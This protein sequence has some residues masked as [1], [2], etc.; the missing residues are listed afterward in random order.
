MNDVNAGAPSNAVGARTPG[1]PGQVGGLSLNAGNAQIS[2]SW[3]EPPNN[4]E[5]ITSYHLDIDPGGD[6]SSGD[7][8]YVFGG[9]NNGTQYGIRVQACN[10][11]GCGAWS[12]FQYATPRAPVHV[13]WSKGASAQGQPNCGSSYCRW[14]NVSGSGLTPGRTYSVQCYSNDWGAV[15]GAEQRHRQRQR[16]R[17]GRQRLLLRLP[18]RRFL[19]A[20]RAGR[21]RERTPDLRQL[22]INPHCEGHDMQPATDQQAEWFSHWFNA[23]LDNV[24]QVIKGKRDQIALA[25]VCVFSEGHLLVDDVPGTGKTSLAKAIAHSVKGTWSRIQFTPD[26]LPSDVTGGLVYNQSQGTFDFRRGAVF[27]NVVLADEINR[28]SPKTQAALLEVMEERHVTV[29]GTGY[30][31][32]RPFVVLATQN[33]VEQ[34]G[35]YRLPEAQLDRFLMR[36][37]L[38]YPDHDHEVDVLRMLAD[39]LRP[40]GLSPVMSTSDVRNMI[41][42]AEHVHV[43]DSIRS[44]VVRLCAATRTLPELRLGVS[45]RGAIGMIRTSRALAAAQGR[46]FVTADDVRIVA[47]AVMGHRMLLTPEAELGKVDPGELVEQI[48]DRVD[49]PAAMRAS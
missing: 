23:L 16:R 30:D 19:G 14:I 22:T 28:A 9:L 38:G 8:S 11:V 37:T 32:P 44:Y 3:S 1:E 20:A 7:R 33:P 43:E 4:G 25:L 29:D 45:T 17:L 49:L 34:E 48:I 36:T 12:G 46:P 35:T 26:L 47:P 24:E 21:P 40:E 18:Q 39:G 27:A 6:P 15:G 13:N 10:A 5:P 31:V 41:E 2:A 42:V